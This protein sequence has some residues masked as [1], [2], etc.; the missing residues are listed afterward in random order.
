MPGY[1]SGKGN[2]K[3]QDFRDVWMR[4]ISKG[5]FPDHTASTIENMLKI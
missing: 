5:Q 1:I 2:R 3:L 4:K